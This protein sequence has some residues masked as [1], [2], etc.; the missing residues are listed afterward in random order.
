[1]QSE[2]AQSVQKSCDLYPIAENGLE[3]RKNICDYCLYQPIDEETST[4]EQVKR[5]MTTEDWKEMGG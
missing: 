4:G 5:P 2:T 1:M 3:A